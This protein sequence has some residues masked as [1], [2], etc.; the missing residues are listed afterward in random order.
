MPI[1]LSGPLGEDEAFRA[2]A[3]N[4]GTQSGKNEQR[5]A[6]SKSV[7]DDALNARDRGELRVG[8]KDARAESYMD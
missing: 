6:R 4:D 2:F 8:E 1:A 5:K 7:S 3:S